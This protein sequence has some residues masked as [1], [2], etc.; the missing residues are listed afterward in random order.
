MTAI[1]SSSTYVRVREV[2]DVL[3]ERRLS[4]RSASIVVLELFL[5]LG[6]LRAGVAKI[7]S[8]SWW[9]GDTIVEFATENA[10]LTLPWYAPIIEHVIAPTVQVV[11]AVTIVLQL[12]IAASLLTGYFLPVGLFIA[13]ALNINII[14]AG[15]VDPSIF[16]L[17]MQAAILLWFL[18][19]RPPSQVLT[20]WVQL[21]FGAALVVVLTSLP[22]IETLQP[23][24][25]I[26]DPA[27]VLVTFGGC[28]ATGCALIMAR[29][30][31]GANI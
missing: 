28:L 19:S 7:I 13:I 10:D 16:Y 12:L 20:R 5:G 27:M 30:R 2:F 3:L 15:G 31:P 26:E 25:V 29:G 22:F 14:I 23:S 4:N 9:A 24:G 1:L 8:S 17:I 18:E 6:W 11:A 21:T